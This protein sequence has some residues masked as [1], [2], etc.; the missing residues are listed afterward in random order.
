ML[1]KRPHKNVKVDNNG[2]EEEGEDGQEEE[3]SQANESII[4]KSDLQPQNFV[5]NTKCAKGK[6]KD[7][8]G[9][10]AKK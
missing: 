6:K 8:R 1:R 9:A 3:D 7:E 10:N 4:A 5:K 2:D